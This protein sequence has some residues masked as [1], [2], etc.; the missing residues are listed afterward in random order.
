MNGGLGTGVVGCSS[1]GKESERQAIR[2]KAK[3][4]VAV[5][6]A[7]LGAASLPAAALAHADLLGSNPKAGQVLDR[8]PSRFLLRFDEAI[9]IQ[10]VQLEVR[11]GA[12][13]PVERGEPF[14]PDGR[15]EHIAV[16]LERGLE[17]T[18]IASYRVISEDG[19]PVAKRTV[20][21]VRAPKEEME[22][23]APAPGAEPAAPSM[24]DDAGEHG[25]LGA[26][27][28]TDAGFA[29]ARGIGYLA[30]A[31]AIGGVVFL[32]AA[33]MPGLAQAAGAGAEWRAV[34]T[35]FVRLVKR[36]VVGAVV[37]GLAATAGAIVFEAA[38]ATGT[39]FW[40]ALDSN[41]IDAVSDTRVVQVWTA[42]LLVWILFG[43]VAV[44]ILRSRR[45]PVLRRAA[46]GAVGTAPPPALT[47]A[48]LL[49]LGGL[50]VALAFTAP[51]A[52]HVQEHSPT[53]LLVCG[54]TLHVLC[55]CTWLGGLAMLLLALPAAARRLQPPDRTR[56]WAAVGSRFSRYALI[57][58]AV[59]LLTGIVQSVA[60]VGSVDAL[61]ET[62][63]GRLVLAKIALFLALIAFGAFNQRRL[64]PQLRALAEAG[65][66]PGRAAALLRRSVAFEVSL[67]LVVLGVTSVLVATQPAVSA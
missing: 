11:D 1:E 55:M 16:R 12:G 21:R 23:A 56:L 64:L 10:L 49:L 13:R 62:A 9:D 29:V 33:W 66:E 39:S 67:V 43:V 20:F 2:L 22:R 17:G 57:A 51:M 65:D 26:G 3:L 36:I 34:S 28:I 48:Q 63:Y 24:G 19:H 31:L 40:S 38:T 42:R 7:L 61:V 14:H 37:L 44:A 18:L 50:M 41:S 6:A 45:A 46:L 58:V 25:D 32:L 54:D 30:M 53:A 4:V 60:L 47:R 27:G 59:L 5:V 35:A 8:S 52:G 15:D